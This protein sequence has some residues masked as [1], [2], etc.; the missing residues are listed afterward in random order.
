MRT[1]DSLRRTVLLRLNSS[2]AAICM[3]VFRLQDLTDERVSVDDTFNALVTL[4]NER[5]DERMDKRRRNVFFL[6]ILG[7]PILI[8]RLNSCIEHDGNIEL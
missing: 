3:F 5:R 6:T 7:V 8:S 4:R 2:V 1:N